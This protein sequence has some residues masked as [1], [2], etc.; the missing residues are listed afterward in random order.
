M[1][2][3]NYFGARDCTLQFSAKRVADHDDIEFILK[4]G[5]VFFPTLAIDIAIKQYVDVFFNSLRLGRQALLLKVPLDTT[6]WN[7]KNMGICY[8]AIRQIS[9][10]SHG[11][12]HDRPGIF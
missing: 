11:V 2:V 8:F 7:I 5:D 4:S 12:I 10:V 1:N 6:Q 9:Q 3:D